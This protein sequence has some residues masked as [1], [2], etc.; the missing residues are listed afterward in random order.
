MFPV[1]QYSH[2]FVLAPCPDRMTTLLRSSAVLET[3][4]SVKYTLTTAIASLQSARPLPEKD[5]IA[6]NQKSWPET[7]ECMGVKR[8]PKRKC[9]PEERGLTAQSIGV[10]KAKRHI[11]TDPYAGGERSGKRAKPDAMSAAAN[12]CAR[13]LSPSGTAPPSNASAVALVP[14]SASAPA[15]SF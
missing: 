12:R 8:A 11:H 6:P 10:A 4:R 2:L 1:L 3:A 14:P 13:G 5:V 7:A 9:P 15:C